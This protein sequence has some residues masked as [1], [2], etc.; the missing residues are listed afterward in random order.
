MLLHHRGMQRRDAIFQ[1]SALRFFSWIT[2]QEPVRPR[3]VFYASKLLFIFFMAQGGNMEVN[4]GFFLADIKLL[5]TG[6][7]SAC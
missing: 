4:Y 7:G 3:Y 1:L 6:G 2:K 5:H